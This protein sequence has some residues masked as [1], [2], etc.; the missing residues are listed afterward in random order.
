MEIKFTPET[1]PK[2]EDWFMRGGKCGWAHECDECSNGGAI[3]P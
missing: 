2:S 3:G 1:C